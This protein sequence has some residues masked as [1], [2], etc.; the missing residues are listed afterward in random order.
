MIRETGNDDT[1]FARAAEHFVENKVK[2]IGTLVVIPFWDEI[3]RFNAQVRPALRKAGLLGEV[4]VVREAVKPLT[5]TAEQKA[6]WEQY[7]VGDRLVFAR[8]TRFFKRGA[9]AEVVAVLRDGIIARGPNG[10]EAKLTRKQRAAFDVGRVQ[11]LAVAAGDRLLIRGRNDDAGFANG[12]FK[13]VAHVDPDANRIVFTDGRELPPGFAAW[14][15]GHA[16]TSYRSQGSTSEESLL[17]LG[18]VAA[19]ALARR[20]FYVGNTRFRGA[21]AIYVAN[22]D[23]ILARLNR[24]DGGREL[25][26]EFMQRHRMSERER[27]VPRVIRDM[28]PE[29]RVAWLAATTKQQR[30]RQQ[31]T[32]RRSV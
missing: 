17:V 8:S 2:G 23:E 5:W 27:F 7:H 11:T 15:Y 31:R 14:T 19:R 28:R 1:L 22:K 30:A 25:A 4:E 18:E 24:T 3:E 16:I 29:V 20:Q 21:H 13:E 9:S 10:R 12:D 32:E 6:H 26:T